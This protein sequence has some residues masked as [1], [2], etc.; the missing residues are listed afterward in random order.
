MIGLSVTLAAASAPGTLLLENDNSPQ[1]FFS[2]SAPSRDAYER[3]QRTFGTDSALRLVVSGPGI[4]TPLGLQWLADLETQSSNVVG[5]A[6]VAGLYTHHSFHFPDWPPPATLFRTLVLDDALDID[7]GWVSADGTTVTVIVALHDLP[8]NQL[9]ETLGGFEHLLSRAPPE[10]ETWIAGLPV[11]QG[12]LDRALLDF[13]MHYLPVLGLLLVG[14]LLL[15]FRSFASILPLL[16]LVGVCEITLLGAMGYSG[17]SLNMITILLVPLVLVISLATAVHIMLRFRR[18]CETGISRREAVRLTYAE[19]VWPVLWTG[20]TT[21]VAFGSLFTSPVPP[22]KDLG[23]W[24]ALGLGLLTA[25]TLTLYPALLSLAQPGR[26]PKSTPFEQRLRT[27]GRSCAHWAIRRR[28]TVVLLFAAAALVWLAGTTR[29]DFQTSVLSYFPAQE[30]DGWGIDQLESAGIGLVSAEVVLRSQIAEE[31]FFSRAASI[32]QLRKLSD[33]LRSLPGV[34]AVVSAAQVLDSL[35]QEDVRPADNPMASNQAPNPALIQLLAFLLTG[36]AR[37]ARVSVLLPISGF[38][39]LDPILAAIES[40]AR[41]SFPELDVELTGRYPLVL[42]SQRRT[43]ETMLSSL[44]IAALTVSAIFILLLGSPKTGLKALL[45]NLWPV[46]FAIGAMGW[47]QVPLDS[48]TVM[49][50]A[51]ALGLVVDDTLHT[52]GLFRRLA[53]SVGSARATLETLQETAGAHCLSS[54]L[55]IS[56]FAVCS[57]SGFLPVARFAAMTALTILMALIGDLILMPVLLFGNNDRQ[58]PH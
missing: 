13:S 55:L 51:V 50:A 11:I 44:F 12:S 8:A 43:L 56:G 33:E 5:V 46:L 23:L 2:R 16:F 42:Q 18:V 21:A 10:T 26:R 7:A 15:V 24:T 57:L 28:R 38:Q 41:R 49:I 40:S 35:Q 53:P 47:L 32:G 19:K 22:V 6:G 25:A 31:P 52:L 48:S 34:I 14:L 4:W 29:L 37:H 30:R 1:T 3:F 36:D 20:L 54:L 58:R 39:E 17:A 45:P 9:R 27:L